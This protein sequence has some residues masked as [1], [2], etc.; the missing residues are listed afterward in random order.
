MYIKTKKVQL[1]NGKLQKYYYI[2]MSIRLGK[3]VRPEIIKYLGKTVSHEVKWW[4]K[5]KNEFL[6]NKR[7]EEL[8]AKRLRK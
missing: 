2:S 3:H 4:L 7:K 5:N 6:R 1:K 8:L